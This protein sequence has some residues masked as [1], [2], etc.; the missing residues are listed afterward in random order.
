MALAATVTPLAAPLSR[1]F[2]F[3]NGFPR[4]PNYVSSKVRSRRSYVVANSAHNSSGDFKKAANLHSS[5]RVSTEDR[6]QHIVEIMVSEGPNHVQVHRPVDVGTVAEH[7]KEDVSNSASTSDVA[8][9]GHLAFVYGTLKKGFGNHWLIEELISKGNAVYLGV[10]RTEKQYPLVCGPFQVPFLVYKPGRGRY[11]KGEL[12]RVNDAALAALD[13]LEGTDRGHYF[14]L[15]LEL[16]DVE[17]AQPS[18]G[19]LPQS[20][21]A[22]ATAAEDQRFYSMPAAAPAGVRAEAYFAG[23]QYAAGLERAGTPL[24]SYSHDVAATYVR[25][26]DRPGGCTFVEHVH[27]WIGQRAPGGGH[28]GYDVRPVRHSAGNRHHRN[29]QRSSCTQEVS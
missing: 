26:K 9:G 23:L 3:A 6:S 4:P 22:C 14:R 16:R 21:P 18:G 24:D 27:E 11:V 28:H 12:Y 29:R 20:P 8:A 5:K 13:V 25:R 19:P 15:P 10:A 17:L 2:S 7:I 1:S